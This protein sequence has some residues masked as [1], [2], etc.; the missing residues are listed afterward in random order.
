MK[1]NVLQDPG[2]AFGDFEPLSARETILQLLDARPGEERTVADIARAAAALDIAAPTVRMA[3]SRLAAEGDIIAP[4][5]G[6]Y[7]T[8]SRR[9]AAQALWREWRTAESRLTAWNGGWRI[10][11]APGAKRAASKAHRNHIRALRLFGFAEAEPGLWARADNL[12]DAPDDM[13]SMMRGAGLQPEARLLETGYVDPATDRFFRAMH[14]AASLAGSYESGAAR[15]EQE[16]RRLA[17][18]PPAEAL[19]ASFHIGRG[20]IRA[21]AF[22]PLLPDELIDVDRRGRLFAAA[23]DYVEAGFAVW[24]SIEL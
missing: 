24:R 15:L 6:V 19:V 20:A 12:T 11:L 10:I 3:L 13:L 7:A 8:G 18:R 22:D 9:S 16:K 1:L 23:R 4:R 2:E 17:T 5:R 21:V 14:D